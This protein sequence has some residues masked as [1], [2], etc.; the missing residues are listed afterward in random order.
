MRESRPGFF[1][2][3]FRPLREAHP[4]CSCGAV[5][6]RIGGGGRH[7]FSC[8]CSTCCEQ[9]ATDGRKAPTWTA[10]SRQQCV[11]KGPLK[12]WFSSALGRRA[13]CELCNGCI[14]MDYSAKHTLYIHGASPTPANVRAD[15]SGGCEV[16]TADADIF[17]KDRPEGAKPTSAAQFDAMPL[18]EMGFVSDPGRPLEVL[19]KGG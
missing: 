14:L 3:L 10:V 15:P 13:N 8:H 12:L 17:W 7:I 11:I 16:C 1:F 4:G 6:V 18:G 9:N 19:E 2:D 5:E